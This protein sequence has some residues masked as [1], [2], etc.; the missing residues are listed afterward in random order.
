[1]RAGRMD[2]RIT[3]QK[4]AEVPDGHGGFDH[5]W[6]DI[7]IVWAQ[8]IEART[9]E[10]MER[11]GARADDARLAFRIRGRPG[12]SNAERVIYGGRMLNIIEIAELGRRN[13]LEL[14]CTSIGAD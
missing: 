8:L 4:L 2:R 10:F 6:T 13:G 1:M 7:C 5:V 3:L 14:R 9:K 11:S 12:V